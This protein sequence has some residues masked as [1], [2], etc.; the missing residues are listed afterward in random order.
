MGVVDGTVGGAGSGLLGVGLGAALGAVLMGWGAVPV[1]SVGAITVFFW[2]CQAMVSPS[3][4]TTVAASNAITSIQRRV[5]RPRTSSTR[6]TGSA[7][8]WPAAVD[9][10]SESAASA[11]I[12]VAE[13]VSSISPRVR[14]RS[15]SGAG[16]NTGVAPSS[17]TGLTSRCRSS[18]QV[19]QVSMW[20]EMRLRIST[21]K[22]PVPAVQDRGELGTAA[23]GIPD[24]ARDQ[25][26]ASRPLRSHRSSGV[27]VVGVEQDVLGV[28]APARR[29]PAT[30]TAV[31][32]PD[33]LGGPRS[34]LQRRQDH[35]RR[36]AGGETKRLPRKWTG[37][38][39]WFRW[40]PCKTATR[41]G[42]GR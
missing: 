30:G 8:A 29:T 19:G 15:H 17:A 32:V 10:V 31:D 42:G 9:S 23:A 21:V 2:I 16:M 6:S 7:G 22:W 35:S 4:A 24:A 12:A 28:R 36:R 11:S 3:D 37:P 27:A 18:S 33:V 41:C 38:R 20:R 26:C 5:R 25:Q 34:R 1:R 14:S 13:A 39:K 40:S